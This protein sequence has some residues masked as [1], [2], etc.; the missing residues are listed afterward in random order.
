LYSNS[1]TEVIVVVEGI[2]VGVDVIVE[3][4]VEV[5]VKVEVGTIDVG[6]VGSGD[7]GK[8]RSWGERAGY[9]GA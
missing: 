9:V 7:G 8:T 3:V 6:V 5:E 1:E 2:V 4:E